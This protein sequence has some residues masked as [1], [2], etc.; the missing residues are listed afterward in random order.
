MQQPDAGSYIHTV[1][2]VM[3]SVRSLLYERLY[4]TATQV[5]Q[6]AAICYC[7]E[8]SREHTLAVKLSR[9]C[10]DSMLLLSN[11]KLLYYSVVTARVAKTQLS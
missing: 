10:T 1:L 8:C 4:S 11:S 9:L 3:Q 5:L 7:D 2:A 6:Q